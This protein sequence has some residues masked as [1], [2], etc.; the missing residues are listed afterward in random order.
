M[1]ACSEMKRAAIL[2]LALL[3]LLAFAFDVNGIGLGGKEIEVK[4][5]MP[6]ALCK[7]LEWKSDAADRRCD[8]AKV[9]VAG[10][11]TRIA[12]FFKDGAV[13]AYDIRF[14]VRELERVK[15]HLKARWGAPLAEATEVIARQGKPDRKVFKMRWEKGAERAVLVAQLEKKRGSLEVSRGNFPVEIY[16]VR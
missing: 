4:K 11:E 9:S 16:Q 14:D 2:V 6:S 13:Q 10:V 1:S 3:P 12:V 8:D 7:A 15:S 5:A